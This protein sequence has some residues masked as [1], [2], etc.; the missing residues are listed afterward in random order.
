MPLSI[1]TKTSFSKSEKYKSYSET[2]SK[3][4]TVTFEAKAICTE[5]VLSLGKRPMLI[6]KS[7]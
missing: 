3:T 6:D 5:F 1:E 2:T 7:C 4:Q